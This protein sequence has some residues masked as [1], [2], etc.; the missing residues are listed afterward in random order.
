MKPVD[1]RS[2]VKLIELVQEEYEPDSPTHDASHLSRVASLATQ[3][4]R[5]EGGNELVVVS[6]SWLHDLHRDRKNTRTRFFSSPEQSDDRARD[7]LER[8]DMP[9]ILHKDILEAIH[10]T[11]THSFSHCLPPSSVSIEAKCLRDADNLDAI[12]AIGIA[13]AFTFGGSYGISIWDPQAPLDKRVFDQNSRP[14]STIHHFHEKLIRLHDEFQTDVAKK[15][16]SK[17]SVYL[18]KFVQCLIEE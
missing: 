16:A 8:A 4:C 12:G 14:S 11:D 3:I 7:F 6:A 1:H 13:R 2:V 10:Y 17:R 5:T 15:L 18:E 9:A